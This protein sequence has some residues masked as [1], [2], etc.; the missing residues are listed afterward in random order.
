ME[1]NWDVFLSYRRKDIPQE[2]VKRLYNEFSAK[3]IRAF[4][5]DDEGLHLQKGE[6]DKI[7]PSLTVHIKYSAASIVFFSE[8]YVTSR[9]CLEELDQILVSGRLLLPV[10][11]NVQP[12]DVRHQTGPLQLG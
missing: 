8:K 5:D 4:R 10:F 9:R 12:T 11:Y 6:N 1:R 3:K 7:C 2:F